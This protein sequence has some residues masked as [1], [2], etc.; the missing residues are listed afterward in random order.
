VLS[1]AVEVQG[2]VMGVEQGKACVEG[3][4]GADDDVEQLL[5]AAGRRRGSGRGEGEMEAGRRREAGR[6]ADAMSGWEV[7]ASGTPLSGNL[8]HVQ[9]PL[10][11]TAEACRRPATTHDGTMPPL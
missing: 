8:L 3:E 7:H 5:T 4:E 10:Q 11:R 6:H 1:Q 2:V 9:D